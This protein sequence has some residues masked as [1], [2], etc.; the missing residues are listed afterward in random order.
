MNKK[1][2]LLAWLVV[3]FLVSQVPASAYNL[4]MDVNKYGNVRYSNPSVLGEEDKPEE[5]EAEDKKE[6]EKIE[7]KRNAS[8]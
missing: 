3:L 1:T 8:C 2:Y 5:H 6:E 4:G 7:S